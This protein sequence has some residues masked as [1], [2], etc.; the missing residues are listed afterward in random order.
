MPTINQNSEIHVLL[1]NIRKKYDKNASNISIGKCP[2]SRI[3][4][5]YNIITEPKVEFYNMRG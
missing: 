5:L 1:K 3:L 2:I 4:D